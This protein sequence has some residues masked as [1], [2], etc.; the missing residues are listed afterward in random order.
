MDKVQFKMGHPPESICSQPCKSG[1]MKKNTDTGCCWTCHSCGEYEVLDVNDDTRC[2]TCVLGTKPNL[3]NTVCVPI[4]EKN[5]FYIIVYGSLLTKTN[6]ISRIFNSPNQRPTFISPQSQLAICAGL[7]LI[8]IFI[9][10][11][12]FLISPPEAIHHYPTR[13]DNLLVCKAFIGSKYIIAFSYPILLVVVC[14]I[15]A[16]LTRKIPE[17]FNESKFIGFSMY[18]TCVI[19][20]AF[21]PI[22]FA[23]RQRVDLRITSMTVTVSLSASVTVACLFIPKLYIILLHPEKNIRQSIMKSSKVP[24]YFNYQGTT[25]KSD[26][27]YKNGIVELRSRK[28]SI[29]VQASNTSITHSTQTLNYLATG[30]PISLTQEVPDVRL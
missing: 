10:I 1:E 21:I 22:F 27:Y 18:T 13:E 16:I 3:F 9:N 2:T 6:R 5:R 4:P 8:Q 20:L 11:V 15:Y 7:V 26:Q 30:P 12:S 17:A 25:P 23:T 14:T 29:G 28:S 19:W 24:K